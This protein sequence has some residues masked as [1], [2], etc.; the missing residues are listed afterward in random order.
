MDY[1]NVYYVDGR[2][3]TPV[4]TRDQRIWTNPNVNPAPAPTRV[5][6][7]GPNTVAW[8]SNPNPSSAPYQYPAPSYYGPAAMP[9]GWTGYPVQP[10]YIMPP[11]V[12]PTSNLASILGGFG[13]IGTLANIV[14]QAFAAFLPLPAAPT[15]QDGT[16]AESAAA[17]AA[18]N[19]SNL[20]RYQ[21]ALAL[22][23][24]RDQQILTLGAVLKELF[25]RPGLVTG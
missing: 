5:V 15:P 9:N 6:T 24:R 20:I 17:N 8:T 1:E 22:F 16:D 19:S 3:A 13:D 23:A 25:K 12:A 18:V 10:P 14:A 4:V 7:P 11:A 2:N 21:N